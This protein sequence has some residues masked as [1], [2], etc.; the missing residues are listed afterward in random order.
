[1]EKSR[2]VPEGATDKET[3]GATEDRD[4]ERRLAARR[5]GQLKKRAQDIGGPGRSAPPPSDGRPVVQFLRC[6]RED[7][8]GDRARNAAVA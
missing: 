7:L 2:E 5:H 8:A 3:F 1:M 6:T 4:G